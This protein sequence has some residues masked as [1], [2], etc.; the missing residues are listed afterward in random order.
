MAHRLV[1]LT[2]LTWMTLFA[3]ACSSSSPTVDSAEANATARRDAGPDGGDAGAADALTKALT[4]A[5]RGLNVFSESDSELTYADAPIAAADAIDAALVLAKLGATANA[6]ARKHFVTT[7]DD[8]SKLFVDVRSAD[9]VG[10]CAGQAEMEQSSARKTQWKTL[11]DLLTAKLS[12]RVL[13]RYQTS[14][15]HDGDGGEIVAFMG[16][17]AN[18]RLVGF[19]FFQVET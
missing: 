2:A 19:F 1:R 10:F 14:D 12:D 15:P 18:G 13:V 17:R 7:D 6:V 5:A 9:F 16:G 3:G 11:G 4:D 8:V